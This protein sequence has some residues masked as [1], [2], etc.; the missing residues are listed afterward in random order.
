MEIIEE[1]II[2]QLQAVST[3]TAAYVNLMVASQIVDS[4]PLYDEALKGLRSSQP[5]PNFTEASS[6]GFRA[7]FEV[8]EHAMSCRHCQYSLSNCPSCGNSL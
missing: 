2:R 7:Y 6:I 3:T 1:A 4:K 5:R 8:M